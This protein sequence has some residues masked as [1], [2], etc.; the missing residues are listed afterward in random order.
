MV[1]L[2]LGRTGVL[3]TCGTGG[4][5]PKTFNI[6]TATAFVA[7]G[8]GVPVVKHGNRAVSSNSGSADVLQA[9]GVAIQGDLA[10]ARQCLHQAG[11]A[12][13]FAPHFH[14]AWRAVSAIR[15]RL[16]VRTIFNLLGPLANP[17]GADYQL[18][19]VNRPELLDPVADALTL[20]GTRHAL[21]VSGDD[22]L[23]EV[24]LTAPT[25]VRDVREGT[26]RRLV[27]HADDFGLPA[28]ELHELRVSGPEESAARVRTILDGKDSAS[29]RIVVANA[30]AALLAAERV[31]SLRQG[32]ELAR[33]AIVTR[34]ALGVLDRLAALT[35]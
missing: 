12:F 15:Q 29:A 34:A 35:L 27:W 5:G 1:S 21:V 16:G 28:C 20:L 2:D 18:L 24:T 17:A 22:G 25:Q 3:D 13:C 19:G 7:A 11:L 32:V 33:Q 10:W 30:A 8:A 6:S 26:V 14:P 31:Q 4:D 23:D 9:L